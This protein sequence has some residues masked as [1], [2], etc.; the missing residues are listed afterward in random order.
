[1]NI[2]LIYNNKLKK[3][4]KRKRK[5]KISKIER[6]NYRILRASILITKYRNVICYMKIY[7]YSF[8]FNKYDLFI[9]IIDI[10][11]RNNNR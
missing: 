1:M 2:K 3:R 10:S 11:N 8:N 5:L 4:K 7:I 6:L 9:T